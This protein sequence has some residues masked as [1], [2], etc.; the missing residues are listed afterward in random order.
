MGLTLKEPETEPPEIWQDEIPP[1]KREGVALDVSTHVVSP[2]LNPDPVT[3]TETAGPPP[4]A[5][6]MF[7]E[8]VS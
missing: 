4:G 3:E 1:A 6:T 7:G 5:E 2:A 8:T